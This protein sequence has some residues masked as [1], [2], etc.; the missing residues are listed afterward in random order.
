MIH[1]RDN[2]P[3]LIAAVLFLT[4]C[5]YI[6]AAVSGVLGEKIRTA[7]AV[8]A[9]YCRTAELYGI[10]IRDEKPLNTAPKAFSRQ[11][12]VYL[13]PGSDGYE[14]L[15]PESVKDFSWQKAEGLLDS[16]AGDTSPGR[17]VSGFAWYYAAKCADDVPDRG[18]CTLRFEGIDKT[19]TAY[20]AGSDS[21][22]TGENYILLRLTRDDEE[23][24]SLRF[25]RGE[26]ICSRRT[27]LE[28]PKSAVVWQNGESFVFVDT[29]GQAQRTRV[30]IIH[31]EKDRCLAAFSTAADGLHRGDKVIKNG[32][33]MYEGKILS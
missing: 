28:I 30:E 31:T 14:Y 2:F 5:A 33:N 18:S 25:V 23:L 29:A 20:V 32:E 4:V 11:S 1:K 6:G 9:E 19:V 24:L 7:E 8:E 22:P 17:A 3:G 12:G 21:S 26:L 16:R 10:V 13:L 27:G 15:S